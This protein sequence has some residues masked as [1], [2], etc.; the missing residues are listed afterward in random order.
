MSFIREFKEFAVKGSVAD[1]G[2]GIV[3]GAAFTTVVNSMVKDIF[4]PVLALFTTGV[5]FANWFIILRKGN[6]GGPYQTLGEAH[7]DNAVTLNIGNF[8]N[9]SISFLIVAIA[10]FFV[11]RM[12]NKLR[13]PKNVTADAIKNKE[14]PYCFSIISLK[15]TRCPFCTAQI[16]DKES[17][18]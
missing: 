6:Q 4:T 11:I 14:C 17:I 10:L 8:V 5:N 9:A 15:A 3:V 12:I 2:I 13:R 18:N 1:M 16:E 7:A